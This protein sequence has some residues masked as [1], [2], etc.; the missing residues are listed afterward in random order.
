MTQQVSPAASSN[1]SRLNK[2]EPQ[3]NLILRQRLE[4]IEPNNLTVHLGQVCG[5]LTY[6]LRC[7]SEL[8][9]AR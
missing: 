5:V 8:G 6:L 2:Q 3:F 7:Y 1:P 9:N 4:Q